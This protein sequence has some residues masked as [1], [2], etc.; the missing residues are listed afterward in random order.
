VHLS[1]EATELESVGDTYSVDVER[2]IELDPDV[3]FTAGSFATDVEDTLSEAG[4]L[5]YS[6]NDVDMDDIYYSI[7]AFGTITNHF[8]EAEDVV[9]GMQSDLEELQEATA[10]VESK[11]VF[12]DL[13]SLYSSSGLSFQG[14]LFSLINATNIALDYDVSAPQLSEEEVIEANPDVYICMSSKEYYSQPDGF[15]EITA[16]VNGDVYYIPY[17]DPIADLVS[18]PGP[19]VVEGLK[20]LAMMIYPDLDL[21]SDYVTDISDYK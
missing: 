11:S 9:D 15:D 13:G 19:R 10:D 8:D 7:L 12:I 20:V 6:T 5:V 18:R 16:F 3:V 1:G 21:T 4:I 14:N 2:I 17:D